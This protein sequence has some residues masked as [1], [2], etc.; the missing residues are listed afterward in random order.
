MPCASMWGYNANDAQ[1]Q[2]PD[3]FGLTQVESCA[4]PAPRMSAVG[5]EW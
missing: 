1:V 4:L 2:Q 3:C 5:P